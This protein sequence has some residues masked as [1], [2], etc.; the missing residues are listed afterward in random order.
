MHD[1]Y[2]WNHAIDYIMPLTDFNMLKNANTILLSD[3]N[4][5]LT[6]WLYHAIDRLYHFIDKLYHVTDW[7]NQVTG[8]LYHAT[9]WIYLA[10]DWKHHVTDWLYHAIHQWH[11]M[12]NLYNCCISRVRKYTKAVLR[13]TLPYSST[14]QWIVW[15]IIHNNI[16]FIALMKWHNSQISLPCFRKLLIHLNSQ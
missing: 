11:H 7:L 10:T 13:G 1:G 12:K 5:P 2:T 6:G 9:D 15:D 8:W 3:C 14:M 16:Q 4:K